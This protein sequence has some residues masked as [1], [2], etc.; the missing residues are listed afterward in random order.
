[1]RTGVLKPERGREKEYDIKDYN[2]QVWIITRGATRLIKEIYNIQVKEVSINK[3]I[4]IYGKRMEEDLDEEDLEI[5][6]THI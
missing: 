2:K 4:E 1:M 3:L 6:L 5:M